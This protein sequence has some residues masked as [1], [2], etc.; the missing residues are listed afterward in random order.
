M[1]STKSEG[2]K[3]SFEE[4]LAQDGELFFTNEGYSMLPFIHPKQD[5]LHIK[6]LDGELELGDVILYSDK[7][8]HY[9][10][11]RLIKIRKDGHFISAGDNNYWKD[12]PIKRECVLGKLIDVTY[13]NGKTIYLEEN[14][15]EARKMAK[16]YWKRAIS[17]RIKRLFKR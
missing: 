8:H 9:V 10:L 5:I 13:P 7:P 11:H 14:K 2:H 16:S 1:S 6:K 15:K 4:V 12:R 17:L 3:S